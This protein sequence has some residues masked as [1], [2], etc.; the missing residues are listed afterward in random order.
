M[1]R[2]RRQKQS[3]RPSRKSLRPRVMK[4]AR[5]LSEAD[6]ERIPS[7]RRG[8]FPVV[9]REAEGAEEEPSPRIRELCHL[10]DGVLLDAAPAVAKTKTLKSKIPIPIGVVPPEEEAPPAASAADCASSRRWSM[11]KKTTT[12]TKVAATTAGPRTQTAETKA[13]SETMKK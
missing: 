10:V 2:T 1:R 7:P 11:A 13:S 12:T 8:R 5:G 4:S 6:P 9:D 3:R